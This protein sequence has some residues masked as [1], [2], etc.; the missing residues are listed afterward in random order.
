VDWLDGHSGGLPAL[1]E[2]EL[3]RLIERSALERTASGGWTL[4]A[5]TR[6]EADR[7]AARRNF[8][9]AA[10]GGVCQLPPH[11]PDFTGRDTELLEL[12]ELAKEVTAGRFPTA[13]V[14][15]I[16]GQPGAGKT[17]MAV[18]LA[19]T[20]VEYFPDGQWYLDLRGADDRPLEP[21]DALGRLLTV[22]G[23]PSDRIPVDLA[24]R[25]ALYRS[26][27]YDRRFLV[28]LDN[29]HNEA[30]VRPL[31]PS[32]PTLLVLVT[33]RRSLAGLAGARR[34]SL[35]MLSPEGAVDLLAQ[36][37]GRDRLMA[38]PAA[39][40][41]LARLCGLLPLA[42]RIA[43]NRLASRPNWSIEHLT[44][45]LRDDQR[46]L[47][48]LTAGDLQ[49][50]SAF[51]VSYGQLTDR[52]Q[53]AFRRLS[54]LP[55]TDFDAAVAGVLLEVDRFDA[56]DVVEELV[57]V[58]LIEPAPTPG[59]YRFHDL[60]RIFA[61]DRLARDEDE[62]GTRATEQRVLRWLLDAAARAALLIG[63]DSDCPRP[64][65][66]TPDAPR[67]ADADAAQ[68]WLDLEW[69]NWLGAVRRAA[70]LG[71]HAEVLQVA[72]A[73]HWYSDVRW[74]RSEWT[75]VFTFGLAAAR[76]LSDRSAECILLDF[77]AWT[78]TMQKDKRDR[79]E[80]LLREA[81][82]LAREVGNRKEEGWALVYLGNCRVYRGEFEHAM[83]FYTQS[84]PVFQELDFPAGVSTA[85][86]HLGNALHLAGRHSESLRRQ[87][88]AIELAAA[89]GLP[90]SL[91]IAA[92]RLGKALTVLDRPAE[93]V[94]RYEQAAAAHR[95]TGSIADVGECL[96][97][98][99]PLYAGLGRT[100][101]AV[102]SLEEAIEIFGQMRD[103]RKQAVAMQQLGGLLKDRRNDAA[104]LTYE[105]QAASILAQLDGRGTGPVT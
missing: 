11:I 44:A 4:T 95:E 30:Q 75:E 45:R 69:G 34:L 92:F 35:D 13:P 32:S 27:T 43:G 10:G 91:A 98:L 62:A 37:V 53:A 80:P 54:L 87:E 51:A 6:A 40:F 103:P 26:L 24:E 58:S 9:D 47:E 93:A 61:G 15:S 8:Q 89:A 84:I 17:A 21:A 71:L 59:R 12:V 42:L 1:A 99:A 82:D 79:A 105:R 19:H 67:L 36:I 70:A 102:R 14:A 74:Y 5:T 2:R 7:R 50:S 39:A 101:E 60:L 90:I 23:V 73:M 55:G 41:E 52:A 96:Y 97:A 38:E 3:N 83:E 57:D 68:R 56:E 66:P 33:S 77:V 100:A 31:L 94:Q 22:L 85:L 64:G 28:V 63:P 72:W 88:Q 29:A 18:H 49:V 65:P 16:Y 86:S 104:A 81:L 20:L 48:V 46:R 78:Y 25:S 76:A